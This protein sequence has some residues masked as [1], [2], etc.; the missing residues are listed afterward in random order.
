MAQAKKHSTPKKRPTKRGT[1]KVPKRTT[2]AVRSNTTDPIFKIVD[3]KLAELLDRLLVVQDAGF[4]ACD[5]R[6]L[7][8]AASPPN[9]AATAAAEKSWERLSEELSSMIQLISD[10]PSESVIGALV[11]LSVGMGVTCE[12]RGYGVG[13]VWESENWEDAMVDVARQDLWR[14]AYAA[15]PAAAQKARTVLDKLYG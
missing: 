15:H 10:T 12:R 1:A 2:A 4:A 3:A 8:E 13:K 9:A 14:L 7:L 11:K 5:N 6:D